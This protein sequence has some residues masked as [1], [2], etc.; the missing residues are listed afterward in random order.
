MFVQLHQALEL[1]FMIL[2]NDRFLGPA[3][4]VIHRGGW[5]GWTWKEIVSEI[6]KSKA[7]DQSLSQKK[8]DAP[9]AGDPAWRI[10]TRCRKV[11]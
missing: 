8:Y 6:V 9:K 11:Q 3:E 1:G 5:S 7:L 2:S 4:L 10:F